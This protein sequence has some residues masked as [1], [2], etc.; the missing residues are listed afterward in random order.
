MQLIAADI[1]NSSSK[2]AVDHTEHDDRWCMETI[3][4]GDEPIEFDFEALDV[5]AEP[6][7]WAVSSVNA[8]R[9]KRLAVWVARNRP[10]DHFH[11]I[12]S[13]DVE[14][15]TDVQSRERL[16]RDRLVAALQ[17]VSLN[18]GG[19]LIVIDAGTAVTIDFVDQDNVFQ[20]G[21]IFPGAFSNLKYLAEGTDALPDL[22]EN[23]SDGLKPLGYLDDPLAYVGKCTESAILLGVYQTQLSAIRVA[24]QGISKSQTQP[25]SR[26]VDVYL[27]GGGIQELLSWVPETWQHVPDLVL[28]GAKDIGRELLA[29]RFDEQRAA[30]Q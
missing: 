4:R 17:A 29:Q 5:N 30:K 26:P 14:L 23:G 1:G 7:F 18:E 24:V 13:D 8:V 22:A 12:S 6:A 15:K 21:M 28:R 19:P 9:Q 11:V 25:E 10:Q 20:G 3:F 16:G 2:V 27:T